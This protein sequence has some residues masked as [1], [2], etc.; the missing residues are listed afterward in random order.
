MLHE[1]VSHRVSAA[2][3]KAFY[4]FAF[5]RAFGVAGGLWEDDTN[6]LEEL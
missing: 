5:I 3:A 1:K 2:T 6:M 4:P